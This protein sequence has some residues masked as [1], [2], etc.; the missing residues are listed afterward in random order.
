[1]SRSPHRATAGAVLI[2]ALAAVAAGL[3]S[4][5]AVAGG[6]T[7]AAT[8]A[9]ASAPD[10]GARNLEAE[11]ASGDVERMLAVVRKAV[12]CLRA[13]GYPAGDP[14]VHG[15]SVVIAGW[16]PPLDSPA[17]R[18]TDACSFPDR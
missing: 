6:S 17:G 10:T 12:D 18:A 1:V 11:A 3:A 13:N 2:V 9:V 16:N 14:Q 7:P 8:P 5:R 15:R 4:G